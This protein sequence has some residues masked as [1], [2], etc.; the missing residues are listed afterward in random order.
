MRKRD[1]IATRIFALFVLVGLI[2]GAF[3]LSNSFSFQQLTT[4]SRALVNEQLPILVSAAK[5]AQIGGSITTDATNLALATNV[6]ALQRARQKLADTLPKLEQVTDSSA[7]S[8]GSPEFA[9][10]VGR[11]SENI[12][13]IYR[14]TDNKLKRQ[15]ALRLL[16]QQ[17]HWLQIDFVEEVTPLITDSQYN[18]NQML[19]KLAQ[20]QAL[21]P[22]EFTTL[23]KESDVQVQLLK[24]EA[25]LNLVLDLLQRA[26]LF[27][28]RNDILTAQSVI[29]E[30]LLSIDRQSELLSPYPS[31]VTIRQ[32]AA[33]VKSM[34]SGEANVI[35]QS[36]NVVDLDERNRELLTENQTLIE[37]VRQLINQAVAFAEKQNT[38]MSQALIDV[39]NQS[40]KQLKFTLIG[41]VIL[42]LFVGVY[43][44]SQLLNRLSNVLRSM[45]HLAQGELQPLIDIRGKDEVSSLAQATNIFN[46]QARQVKENTA[47][48][49][50]KNRQLTEE[51]QQRKLAE[52]HLQDTQEELVQ[53]AKLAV[54]G[55]LTSG[56]VHEFSQPLAAISSY[57]YLAEQYVQQEKLT[58]AQDKLQR[59]NRIT[60]RATRLCQHL[61]S[62]ARKTDDLTQPTSV[63]RVLN[64]ALDLFTDSLPEAWVFT[65]IASELRVLA[66]EVRLEQVFVNLISNSID[67]IKQKQ[68]DDTFTPRIH[69]FARQEND[70]VAIHIID[71]GCGMN[72]EAKEKVF[73]P[74]YTTKEVGSGLGLGMSI[75]H[76]IMKDFGG[77]I[78]VNSEQ[79]QG[80]EVI[81]C[82]KAT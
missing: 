57:T 6:Q 1:S 70:Q 19:E 73:E 38:E 28:D 78:A 12:D 10:L 41:I 42:I 64:N 54:L 67:A 77:K 72:A 35:S 50:M 66:N 31:T 51:I 61:K 21:T 15:N 68:Q 58:L 9:T 46:E 49:E 79:G 26:S 69:I 59:I 48:L 23:R 2:S 53:A 44:R 13:N 74:F 76:N 65:E 81:L 34:T 82:L 18:L 3:V 14:N 33:Q 7:V 11:L 20:Q 32:M 56:I 60:D 45:R 36:L 17:L 52:K 22:E 47:M 16:R 29:D 39:I 71:N 5:V 27:S 80:T 37:H 4:S 40:S 62:F 63:N 55:Q 24:L 30:T 75:T 43:L 8:Q 25:D